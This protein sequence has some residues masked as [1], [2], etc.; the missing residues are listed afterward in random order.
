MKIYL[1]SCC[2]NRPF[3]N[4]TNFEVYLESQAKMFIQKAIRT[5]KVDLVTSYA[6][7]VEIENNKDD[8]KRENIFNFIKY[9]SPFFVGLDKADEVE[10]IAK[11]IMTAGIKRMDACLVASAIIS[12]CEYF[13]STDKRLLKYQSDK[14]KMINPLNFISLLME[15]SDENL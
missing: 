9:N 15:E 1:D 7:R 4:Q 8:F 13:I 14:I 6:L 2:Y 11:E 5:H 12:G 3:D 10:E